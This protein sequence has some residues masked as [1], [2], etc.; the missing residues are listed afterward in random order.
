MT[1]FFINFV[2]WILTLVSTAAYLVILLGIDPYQTTLTVIILFFASL[3][4]SLAGILAL[5]GYYLR[6]FIFQKG[7]LSTL[8]TA[9]RQ[10]FLIS[11]L[12]VS[13][14]V[15]YATDTFIAWQAILL[16]FVVVL[17]ELYFR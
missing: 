10:G 16:L 11:L 9:I 12:V 14:L 6:E 15:M 13:I 5:A 8:F 2:V 1:I 4:I 17:L 3:F 7:K